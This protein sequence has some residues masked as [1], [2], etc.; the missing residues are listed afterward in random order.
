MHQSDN[1]WC[2]IHNVSNALENIESL[3]FYCPDDAKSLFQDCFPCVANVFGFLVLALK[4]G[5][6]G[7]AEQSKPSLYAGSISK[8]IPFLLSVKGA[9]PNISK[10]AQ[11]KT[12]HVLM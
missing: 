5:Y 12:L 6:L 8:P 10:I 1:D 4:C 3:P 2:T 7:L 11:H 9:V